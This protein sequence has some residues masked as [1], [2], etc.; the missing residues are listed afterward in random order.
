MPRMFP[1]AFMPPRMPLCRLFRWS[2]RFPKPF[3][4]ASCNDSAMLLQLINFT[5][6]LISLFTLLYFSTS[7]AAS[8]LS[9]SV[10]VISLKGDSSPSLLSAGSVKLARQ[11]QLEQ[12]IMNGSH[13]M[14][15]AKRTSQVLLFNADLIK[16][17]L[18]ILPLLGPDH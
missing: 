3:S 6:L 17:C 9:S 4:L 12:K 10:K 14:G 2:C 1:R 11:S 16:S 18:F 15:E 13:L 8:S 7:L 5:L